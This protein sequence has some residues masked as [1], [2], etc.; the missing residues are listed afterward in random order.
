MRIETRPP[1]QEPCRTLKLSSVR[2][3]ALLDLSQRRRRASR[4]SLASKSDCSARITS[5]NVA[6]VAE[7]TSVLVSLA[8]ALA[9]CDAKIQSI[10]I[11]SDE[12]GYMLCA[13]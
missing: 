3:S 11:T 5:D 12:M 7:S 13:R 1:P 2:S 4:A 10:S 8:D 9:A 6:T